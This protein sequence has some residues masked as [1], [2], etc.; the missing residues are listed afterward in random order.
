M[1][2]ILTAAEMREVDR[3]T[4][5][6]GIPGPILMENAGHRVVE[7]LEKRFAPLEQKRV[8]ILCGIGNNGG[9]GYVVAR[10]LWTRFR[11]RSLHVVAVLGDEDSEPRRMLTA[12][13][14]PVATEIT[15]EMRIASLV[16]DAVLGTGISG[17]AHG[18]AL[19]AIRAINTRFPLAQVVAVDVP[20]GMY[21]DGG[22]S[23]GEIARAD[24]TVTFTAPKLCHVF[25]PNCE[26]LGVLH[27][28]AIGSPVSL[29]DSILLKRT[30]R[31]DC[32]PL[33][34]P[35][36]SDSNK[37][38][39]GHVLV[40]GGSPGKTGAAEM[41]SLAALRAGAGLVTVSTS[42]NRYER[43]ELML[44]P[45]PANWEELE[46]S[47]ERMDVIAI[48]PGLGTS[49]ETVALV[50]AA[51]THAKQPMVIDADGLNALAGYQWR[52]DGVRILTPHPGEMSRLMGTSVADVQKR[53]VEVAREY[54]AAHHC[55]LVLKGNRTIIAAPEGSV[56]INPTGS[57]AMATGGT[58]DILTG[59]IAGFLAQFPDHAEEAT[60]TAVW[61]HGRSGELG[62]QALGEK[63][64]L[65]TD[66]LTYLPE[67]IEGC[68]YD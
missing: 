56:W 6:L 60:V 58:G 33:L 37:G 66:L 24:A 13:G 55:F 15:D 26:Q 23:E 16:V 42:A 41:T 64:L 29:M 61:L 46:R 10:Q 20:S 43:P 25:S 52:S 65:A 32:R 11:L 18:R 48:G 50:R 68:E 47:A 57:P 63:S 8:V 38:M 31:E 9:D 27:I 2:K 1:L 35:R 7:F 5:E 39:Y 36:V 45:L 59:M 34:A 3:Q 19:D 51:V 53:R 30:G 62:A 4:I 22:F 40:V 54:A 28:A 14:C 44:Q 67:A 49:P 17:A 12:C 21:T